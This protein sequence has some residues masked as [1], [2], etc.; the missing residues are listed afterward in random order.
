LSG[1]AN[2]FLVG[3]GFGPV[4]GGEAV[5]KTYFRARRFGRNR[6]F[7]VWVFFRSGL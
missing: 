6:R 7:I 5:A 1:I 3:R 4:M 2:F